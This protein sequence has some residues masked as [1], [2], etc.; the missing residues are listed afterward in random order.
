MRNGDGFVEVVD[1]DEALHRLEDGCWV[2]SAVSRDPTRWIRRCGHRFQLISVEGEVIADKVGLP[3]LGV[4]Q[5]EKFFAMNPP[6]EPKA[7]VFEHAAEKRYSLLWALWPHLLSM[8]GALAKYLWYVVRHKFWVGVAGM[9]MIRLGLVSWRH[10]LP[11]VWRLMVHDVSKLRPSELFSYAAYF[12]TKVESVECGRARALFGLPELAPPG[13]MIKDH[14]NVSWLKHQRRNDHHWQY[15]LLKEDDGGDAL[16]LSMPVPAVLEMVADWLGAGRA[17]TGKWDAQ[18]W[19]AK[20]KQ[21]IV[22]RGETRELVERA[23]SS[24]S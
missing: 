23:L 8:P 15:W 22:L 3:W 11:F 9:R 10:F 4:D 17:I 20:N 13:T 16:P 7:P 12:Y 6:V 5:Q 2:R 21:N 18:G 19:Y 24:V 14:F 1:Y